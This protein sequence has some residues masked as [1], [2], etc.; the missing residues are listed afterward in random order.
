M[1]IAGLFVGLLFLWCIVATTVEVIKDRGVIVLIGPICYTVVLV[2][3]LYFFLQ[4][5][6]GS[7]VPDDICMA[8][9]AYGCL[10]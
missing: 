4:G 9:D 6:D 5:Y 3:L 10:E 8:R 2:G 7:Y 1:M